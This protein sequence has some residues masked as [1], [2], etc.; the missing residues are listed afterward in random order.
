MIKLWAGSGLLWGRG[1][2]RGWMRKWAMG[3]RGE[4]RDCH[5]SGVG[6]WHLRRL[7]EKLIFGRIWLEQIDWMGEIGSFW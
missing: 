3:R 5:V 1:I 4:G 6:G 7:G 2:G